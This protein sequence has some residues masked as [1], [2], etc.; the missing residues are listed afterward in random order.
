[1]LKGIGLGLMNLARNFSLPK[2]N[3]KAKAL[4][5]SP[6]VGGPIISPPHLRAIP[7]VNEL[8]RV[9]GPEVAADALDL[10]EIKGGRTYLKAYQGGGEVD[11]AGRKYMYPGM[12][13]SPVIVGGLEDISFYPLAV[14]HPDHN[15][16]STVYYLEKYVLTQTKTGQPV[17]IVDTHNHALFGWALAR[18]LGLT[19]KNAALVHVDAHFDDE[20][21]YNPNRNRPKGETLEDWLTWSKEY[22]DI[23][24]F[25]YPGNGKLFNEAIFVLT[26]NNGLGIDREQGDRDGCRQP[27][28]IISVERVLAEVEQLKA[29]GKKVIIDLD[30]D[31]FA[32]YFQEEKDSGVEAKDRISLAENKRQIKELLQ[33]ADFITVATSPDWFADQ[34]VVVQALL[35]ELLGLA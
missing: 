10:F 18:H 23:S 33:Q 14:T 22:A 11:R 13:N 7:T 9:F 21:P 27:G 28:R 35:R 19:D 30:L 6:T 26:K 25:L 5:A 12:K 20:Y 3:G 15:S 1:M 8:A 29:N 2:N 31:Y 17:L 4:P 32:H 16:Q 34:Q 24:S